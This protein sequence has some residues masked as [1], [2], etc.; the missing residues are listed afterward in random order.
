M[1]S[2]ENLEFNI[3]GFQVKFKPDDNLKDG[4]AE[5]AVEL[6]RAEASRIQTSAPSLE[7]GQVAL[8]V[9]LKLAGE[10]LGLSEEYRANIQDLKKAAQD[11]LKFVE[12]N[13]S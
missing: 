3:L 7:V 4:S 9:A 5:A 8:L 1:D 6:V 12:T 13:P 2:K 11:A 10:K